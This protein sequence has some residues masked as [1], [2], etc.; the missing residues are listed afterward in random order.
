MSEDHLASVAK[1]TCGVIMPISAT[2]SH[3]EAHWG[4][5]QELLHRAIK[6]ADLDPKNVWSGSA[7]DRITPRILSNLFQADIAIG[8]ISDQNPNVMLEL[9]MRLSS[10][11]PTV[12]VAEKGSKVPF[13]IGDFEVIFYPRDLNILDMEVFFSELNNVLREKLSAFQRGHYRPFLSE[14]P[15]EVVDPKPREI[16]FERYVEGRFDELF[17]RLEQ[18]GPSLRRAVPEKRIDPS[19]RGLVGVKVEFDGNSVDG[20][21]IAEL[22]KKKTMYQ[23]IMVEKNS[24]VVPF[25]AGIVEPPVEQIREALKSTPEITKV[26]LLK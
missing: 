4:R 15:G 20:E 5:V 22:I 19:Q 3:D 10:K 1:A 7:I 26:D 2:A 17:S 18:G 12:V 8:D 24:L 16:S 21:T 6:S 14:L 13:D 25:G 23:S 11:K 9:G